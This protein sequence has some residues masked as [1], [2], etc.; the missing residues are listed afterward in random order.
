MTIALNVSTAL[1]IYSYE[2]LIEQAAAQIDRDDLTDEWPLFVQLVEAHLKRR[3]R[4]LDMETR[5]TLTS[6]TETVSLPDD[7]LSI[8][9]VTVSGSPDRALTALAPSAIPLAS[10]G[11]TDIVRGYARV[12][13]DLQ[14]VPPP[15]SETSF[16]L[17]YLAKFTP[18]TEQSASNWVLDDH[19]DIYL[20][21]VLFYACD[22]IGDE[23]TERYAVIVEG[24]IDEL[25]DARKKDRWGSGLRV[26][27]P[28]WH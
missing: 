1:A 24:L 14:L 2:T 16:D 12:G 15:S 9:A 13:N 3:L 28:A 10:G 17:V 11:S 4:V 23:R 25:I 21:G 22:R 8:R 19:P 18:L 7:C 5:T 20:F 26:I 27:A 6:S